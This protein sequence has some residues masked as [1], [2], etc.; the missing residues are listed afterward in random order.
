MNTDDDPYGVQSPWGAI[1]GFFL[2]QC[3][4]FVALQGFRMFV[5]IAEHGADDLSV[6][7]ATGFLDRVL[8]PLWGILWLVMFLAR[9]T[10]VLRRIAVFVKG[11][12]IASFVQ[13][14]RVP[15]E[16]VKAGLAAL[17][18]LV[19]LSFL[20]GHY[21]FPW[22]PVSTPVSILFGL[23]GWGISGLLAW[24]ARRAPA[25]RQS[26]PHGS[27]AAAI[28]GFLV[29]GVFLTLAC[30]VQ[31]GLFYFH[32]MIGLGV[33]TLISCRYLCHGAR[34]SEPRNAGECAISDS[35]AGVSSSND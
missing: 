22:R 24:A 8:L 17:F 16:L 29:G 3:F 11:R 32:G 10:S 31:P 15:S 12:G 9:Q 14:L 28:V 20:C 18:G 21:P 2:L 30:F 25:Q 4:G 26:E 13:A 5:N 35:R 19:F 23:F 1:A 27:T 34:N 7:N 6:F 33:M